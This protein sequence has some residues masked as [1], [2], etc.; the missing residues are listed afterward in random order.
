MNTFCTI[1][2]DTTQPLF[3]H[4]HSLDTH[5]IQIIVSDDCRREATPLKQ[6]VSFSSLSAGFP[7]R[8]AGILKAIGGFII[9]IVAHEGMDHGCAVGEVAVVSIH[10]HIIHITHVV[11]VISICIGGPAVVVA[12]HSVFVRGFPGLV[13]RVAVSVAV[14]CVHFT[15][16]TFLGSSDLWIERKTCKRWL[17]SD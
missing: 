8:A 6:L 14:R 15:F 5:L 1:H 4:C 2:Y 3:I 9:V 16:S 17:I 13:A 12:V 11:Y 7:R 10:V